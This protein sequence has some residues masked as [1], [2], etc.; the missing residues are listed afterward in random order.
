[1]PAFFGLGP[2]NPVTWSSF[3]R[4]G[5]FKTLLGTSGS[6]LAILAALIFLSARLS[7]RDPSRAYGSWV[8]GLLALQF[9][10]TVIIGAGR[11][12]TTIRG[13]LT[14]GM[15]ESLRMMPLPARH[16][17]VGYLCSAVT[18]SGFFVANFILGLIMTALAQLPP[19][20]WV[21]ANAILFIF[22]A[23]VWTIS[24]FLAFLLKSAGPV[25]VLVSIVGVVGNA[26]LFYVAPGLVV[27]AGP[28]IGGSIFDTRA[29]QTE[30]AAPLAVSVAAQFLVGALFFTGAAR[31]YRRPDALALGAWLSLALLLAIIAISLLSILAPES[32]QPRF[33]AREFG[34]VDPDV[35]FCGSMVLALFVAL[36][37]LANFAR[38]H[39]GWSRGR[40]DDPDLRR[41]VPPPAI[42]G[43]LVTTLLAL[44]LLAYPVEAP[45]LQ[46]LRIF[47][48]FVAALFGFCLSTIFVAAW[49]YRAVD[50]AKVILGI[51]LI[52]YCLVPLGVDFARDRLTD[53]AN[54]P[55]LKTAAALSPIGLLIE[56][57]TQP[58][59][60]LRP[61]AVFH[62]LIPLLPIGLYL[63]T[64]RAKRIPPAP[65]L[66]VR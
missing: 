29:S 16:A 39:V 40:T 15:L 59:K 12:S 18:L 22:A 3:Y 45:R 43:L 35:P 13:D 44:M 26:R 56:T 54:E 52:L 28:L 7:P 14:S 61:A 20:H 53:A 8:N 41:T 66:P 19:S 10:F 55:A 63:R 42:A 5:G 4:K 37:P 9:L 65:P 38:L 17:I 30:F 11:V 57:V 60:D 62:V 51:W 32:F 23:L 6:Y 46:L 1:M 34:G 21:I 27:L 47:A 24:A 49:V 25:L 64:M 31:K 2:D 36:V 33:L 58:E 50:N 48:C